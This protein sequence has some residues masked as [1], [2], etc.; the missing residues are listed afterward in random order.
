[1]FLNYLQISAFS[2]KVVTG[3]SVTY[4]RE[5]LVDYDQDR[6]SKA[7]MDSSLCDL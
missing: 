5:F 3:N 7:Y 4:I 1:M 2:F 6:K